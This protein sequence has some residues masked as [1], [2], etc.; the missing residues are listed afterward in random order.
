[1]RIPRERPTARLLSATVWHQ[2]SPNRGLL[3]TADPAVTN[4]RYH[5]AGG[6]GV[7]YASSSANGAWAELFR[8]HEA[9]AIA[10]SEVIRRMGS[11]RVRRL[12]ILDLTNPRV[13]EAFD[14]SEAELTSD[15]PTQCQRVAEYAHA[16]GYDAILAPS[17]ALEG[18]QTVAIFASAMRKIAEVHSHVGTPPARARRLLERKRG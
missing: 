9:G 15:E 14:I 6:S 12:R 16:S 7:W 11:A 5:Q 1:L 4:G 17:A 10:P 8:H 3:D 18:N 13:R 2:C